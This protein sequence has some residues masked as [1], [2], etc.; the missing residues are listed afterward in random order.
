LEMLTEQLSDIVARKH[1]RATMTQIMFMT[2]AAAEKRR[3][4]SAFIMA[5]GHGHKKKQKE[6]RRKRPD[7]HVIAMTPSTFQDN[8]YDSD[9]DELNLD[10][11][12]YWTRG[13]GAR[14]S[15]L[16]SNIDTHGRWATSTAQMEPDTNNA[17]T[18][19]DSDSLQEWQADH[20]E[21]AAFQ[22]AV[23]ASI[24]SHLAYTEE[25]TNLDSSDEE[26]DN[27]QWSCPECTYVNIGGRR[28]SV[29]GSQSNVIFD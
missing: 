22:L 9:H 24:R 18:H 23:Q 13:R 2:S 8:D 14:R 21:D 20:H 4:L 12:G 27:H 28:C 26:E 7:R 11:M 6:R 15:Q 29:C 5:M 25:M 1:L 19:N 10:L 17:S 3:A 16:N